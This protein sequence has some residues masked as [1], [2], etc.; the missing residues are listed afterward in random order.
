MAKRVVVVGGGVI[1]LATA[2]YC[3][4]RGFAVTLVERN[5]ERRDGCS[6][7]NAGM[8]VPSHFVPLAAPGMVALG[9]RWM[10]NPASP[11]YVKPRLSRELFDWGF[12]FWQAATKERVQ[13]AA[14][15]LRDLSLESRR[16]YEELAALPGGDFGL[17]KK[18]LLLLCKTRHAFDDES[19]T[20]EFAHALGIAAEVLD[21]GQA[22]ALEPGVRMDI[23]GAVYFPQDC[24]LTPGRLVNR[25]QEELTAG[26]ARLLWETEV[27]G[28]RIERDRVL[29]A[30]RTQ[31]G[32]DIEADEFVLCGGS[33]SPSLVRELGLHI[34]IQAGK[35]YSLT[36]PSPRLLPNTCA[37]L[38]EARVAV[39]PMGGA[40]RFGGTMEI[41]G[42]SEDINPVRVRGI[43]DAV[44]RYYPQFGPR[45][46]DGVVPWCGLRP[47][48]PD[49]LPYVGRTARFANLSIAAGHAMKGVSLGPVTGK[50][51]AGVL[52]GDAPPFDI[53]LLSPDRYRR[54]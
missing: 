16:A 50:L 52:A 44:P 14:P 28:W 36:L 38:S 39:T 13:R 6:Y 54:H 20:A 22:A 30:V 37:I 18:G 21:A 41:A 7:G 53:T 26:G 8:I 40:L 9:L 15:L 11:F 4:R 48:S 24:H 10:W 42:M 12:K 47:C 32:T 1:G 5:A 2:Y 43:V 51:I 19:R 3:L 35:G 17:V 31:G 49:G 23:A 46:F 27:S 33:W 29:R 45:D 34:P 25:L